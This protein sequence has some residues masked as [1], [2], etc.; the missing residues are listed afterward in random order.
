MS[1]CLHFPSLSVGFPFSDCLR[2][3]PLPA[4]T[5]FL[6]LCKVAAT[7]SWNSEFPIPAAAP[8]RLQLGP[9]PGPSADFRWRT[10]HELSCHGWVGEDCSRPWRK[11]QSSGEKLGR[12]VIMSV[13][14]FYIFSAKIERE[15]NQIRSYMTPDD[16]GPE[17]KGIMQQIGNY[18]K[19]P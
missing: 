19:C 14:S 8:V 9:M 2:T 11:F 1:L 12:K 18:V 4:G 13:L 17:W 15:G 7:R 16:E 10:T 3:W 6:S 5:G